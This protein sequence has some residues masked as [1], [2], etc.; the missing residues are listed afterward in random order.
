MVLHEPES[1][2][3]VGERLR[4]TR[5]ALGFESQVEIC[6]RISDEPNYPQL[7]NNWEKGR[8]RLSIDN[9]V[10]LVRLFRLT[11]DW[12]FLGDDSGLPFKLADRIAVLRRQQPTP[13]S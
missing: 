9:A 5:L 11:L 4:L 7:W 1:K 8:E 3:A 2:K 6:R 13:R 12:I 10:V